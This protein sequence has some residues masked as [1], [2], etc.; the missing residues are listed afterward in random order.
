MRIALIHEQS[1]AGAEQLA[2]QIAVRSASH[3]I[4]DFKGALGMVQ[5][6]ALGIGLRLTPSG[7]PREK[8]RDE[9]DERLGEGC[10]KTGERHG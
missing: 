9:P 6:F 2:A 3:R 5:A 4:V 10:Q 8:E 1:G 7:P